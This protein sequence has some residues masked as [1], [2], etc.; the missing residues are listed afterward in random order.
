MFLH[1]KLQYIIIIIII[2]IQKFENIWKKKIILS[3]FIWTYRII[4]HAKMLIIYF[5][6]LL[7]YLKQL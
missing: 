6:K 4:S 7:Y 3:F 5:K 2:I 1:V